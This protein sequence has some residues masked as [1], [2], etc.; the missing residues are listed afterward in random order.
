MKISLS[1]GQRQLV[2]EIQ[3]NH[4]F[5]LV[6]ATYMK[7]AN[8]PAGECRAVLLDDGNPFFPPGHVVSMEKHM[9]T[10]VVD[11]GLLAVTE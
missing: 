4:V 9:D 3:L 1:N 11:E 10:L 2:R 6:G 7:V 8:S 5:K